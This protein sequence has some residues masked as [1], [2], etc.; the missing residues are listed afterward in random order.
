MSTSTENQRKK[1]EARKRAG[2]CVYCAEPLPRGA[3][4]VSCAQCRA[5]CMAVHRAK[6]RTAPPEA[7]KLVTAAT[8][9]WTPL[10]EALL[11]ASELSERMKRRG[12]EVAA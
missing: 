9:Q 8:F 4:Y 5:D 1:R 2:L 6:Y 12:L 3:I 10:D 7:V 11:R